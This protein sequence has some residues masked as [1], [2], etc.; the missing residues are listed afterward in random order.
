MNNESIAILR[1][2]VEATA[3]VVEAVAAPQAPRTLIEAFASFLEL[4]VANGDATPDTIES[5]VTTVGL[6][7]RWCG[8]TGLDPLGATKLDIE[9]YRAFLKASGNLV[10]TRARKLNIVRRFYEAAVVHKLI[11]ENPANRVRGGKDPTPPEEKI[12]S[13]TRSALSDLLDSIPRFSLLG[14]RD[15]AIIALMAVHG[16]RRVEVHRLDHA[17][18]QREGQRADGAA[19]LL[20]HGKGNRLRRVFLRDDTARALDAYIEGKLVAGLPAEGALFLSGSNRTRGQ[21]IA[22]RSLNYIVDFHL[23]AQGLKRAGASCHSLRHTHGTLAVAGGAKVEQLR[24][25]MGHASI[26]TTSIYVRAIE[27]IKNNPA[28]FID[29]EV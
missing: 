4:D 29:V 24:D 26:D 9:C 21:R 16:L 19:S 5:Y 8:D 12:K 25:A 3:I 23:E 6:Y 14:Q 17:S 18:Y 22:R 20:I 1:D 13:L 11:G 15:R 2:S 28:N 7:L 27:R 10:T